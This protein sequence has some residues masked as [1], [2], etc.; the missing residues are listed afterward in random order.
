MKRKQISPDDVE[1]GMHIVVD[2]EPPEP[3]T[4]QNP[5]YHFEDVHITVEEIVTLPDGNYYFIY[6]GFDRNSIYIKKNTI[7]EIS[8]NEILKKL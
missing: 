7:I 8:I 6:G 3:H 4:Q 5:Y 1:I 2:P